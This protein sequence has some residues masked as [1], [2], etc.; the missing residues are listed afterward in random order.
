MIF[1]QH[2]EVFSSGIPVHAVT[3]NFK[4]TVE[5]GSRCDVYELL[6]NFTAVLQGRRR[7]HI[8]VGVLRLDLHQMFHKVLVPGTVGRIQQ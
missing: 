4:H 5:H 6:R 7:L 3:D 2:V 1:L 8:F